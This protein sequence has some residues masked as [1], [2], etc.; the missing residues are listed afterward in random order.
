MPLLLAV[1]LSIL[2]ATCVFVHRRPACLPQTW[3]CPFSLPCGCSCL[4]RGEPSVLSAHLPWP[5]RR[6]RVHKFRAADFASTWFSARKSFHTRAIIT[7]FCSRLVVLELIPQ[8]CGR[9]LTRGLIKQ[10]HTLWQN[11]AA[12]VARAARGQLPD[13]Q[14]PRSKRVSFSP[15][16]WFTHHLLEL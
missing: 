5:S 11:L 14:K 1:D 10:F 12:P 3:F 8:L 6:S 9:P 7:P 2:D 16:G 15:L 4:K 13:H